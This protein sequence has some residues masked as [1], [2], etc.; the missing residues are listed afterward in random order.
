MHYTDPIGV[1]NYYRYN[2]HTS[3]YKPEGINIQDDQL[4]NG[5]VIS[6]PLVQF[7][8]GNRDSVHVFIPGDSVHA[9]LISITKE[10]YKYLST[11]EQVTGNGQN[12][13][14]PTNQISIMVG[15]KVQGYF[16]AQSY[17]AKA[18]LIK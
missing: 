8:R 1:T 5:R 15:T 18:I 6:R 13:A 7:G 12:S 9:E 11:L 2:Y 3:F 4:Q 17:S 14:T 10:A 16:S